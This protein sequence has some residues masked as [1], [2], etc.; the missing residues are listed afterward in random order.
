MRR[1][2]FAIRAR[3]HE[4]PR[5]EKMA[6]RAVGAL[7]GNLHRAVASDS[8]HA[9]MT[10]QAPDSTPPNSQ[11]AATAPQGP[12]GERRPSTLERESAFRHVVRIGFGVSHLFS[13]AFIVAAA[14]WALP[15]RVLTVDAAALFLGA[16]FW[17]AG[18]S[19]LTQHNRTRT[20]VK[21][22]CWTILCLGLLLITLLATS[23]AYL[24]TVFGPLGAAG[25]IIF[26]L[27]ICLLLPY[28]VVFP[29]LQLLWLAT[30]EETRQP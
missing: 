30:L 5:L 12:P 29:S 16:L 18:I 19:L 1:K 11:N 26:L 15:V 28:L 24:S 14:L 23:V 3:Y 8:V 2:A 22:A 6:G 17:G 13:G 7:A 21:V 9:P 25:A 20:L 10:D 27:V 4:S